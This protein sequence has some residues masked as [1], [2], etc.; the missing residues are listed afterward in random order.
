M[1]LPDFGRMAARAKSFTSAKLS[2][3]PG[4][5]PVYEQDRRRRPVRGPPVPVTGPRQKRFIRQVGAATENKLLINFRPTWIGRFRAR[6]N[7][8]HSEFSQISRDPLD[9]P[10]YSA[11]T[12]ESVY[13]RLLTPGYLVRSFM[14]NRHRRLLAI[15]QIIH[16]LSVAIRLRNWPG[17]P[18][19]R[20]R[21]PPHRTSRV[22]AGRGKSSVNAHLHFMARFRDDARRGYTCHIRYTCPIADESRTY[23][24]RRAHNGDKAY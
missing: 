9:R 12:G 23:H 5:C 2:G 17:S 14:L 20:P 19:R 18:V 3:I 10:D 1:G 22:C 21:P 11:Q 16:D 6:Y 15:V 4:G 8:R 7:Q 24:A 13:N